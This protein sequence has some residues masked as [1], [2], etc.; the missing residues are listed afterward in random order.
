MSP[1]D[2]VLCVV[3]VLV[4]AALLDRHSRQVHTSESRSFDDRACGELPEKVLFTLLLAEE[5]AFSVGCANLIGHFH[6]C[7][8]LALVDAID[9]GNYTD[10]QTLRKV[11]SRWISNDPE[12]IM[13]MRSWTPLPLQSYFENTEDVRG[14]RHLA[15][16]F[17]FSVTEHPRPEW[18]LVFPLG[19]GTPIRFC[20][21]GIQAMKDSDIVATVVQH[22]RYGEGQYLYV[23]RHYEPL[24][25]AI[26]FPLRLLSNSENVSTDVMDVAVP[27]PV[28]RVVIHKVSPVFDEVKF[29]L[30]EYDFPQPWTLMMIDHFNVLDAYTYK[31]LGPQLRQC[32]NPNVDVDVGQGRFY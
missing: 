25:D 17:N 14:G 12:T 11:Y 2:S 28:C 22:T 19:P 18:S 1:L 29:H 3:V 6:Y 10:L 24:E 16:H 8:H 20:L 21:S 27:T 31:E 4:L 7:H 5:E 26:Q 15:F 23:K 32:N 13:G 9:N 30:C